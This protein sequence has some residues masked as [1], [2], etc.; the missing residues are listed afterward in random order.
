MRLLRPAAPALFALSIAA[1]A[2]CSI[3][4]DAAQYIGKNF[5]GR[6]Y[7]PAPHVIYLGSPIGRS[8]EDGASVDRAIIRQVWVSG[9]P[10]PAFANR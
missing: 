3:E 6:A 10:R 5:K 7:D 8:G 1:S 9:R 4:L 2:A